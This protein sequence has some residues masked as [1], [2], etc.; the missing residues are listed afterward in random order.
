[1]QVTRRMKYDQFLSALAACAD[2]RGMDVAA[3]HDR[4]ASC[5]G[6]IVHGTQVC[7]SDPKR[8]T[9]TCTARFVPPARS[10]TSRIFESESKFHSSLCTAANVLSLQSISIEMSLVRM[11][12]DAVRF[13]DHRVLPVERKQQAEPKKNPGGRPSWTDK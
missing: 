1:M 8:T 11:Q 5:D 7:M 6:P 4:I 10:P 9:V 12:A 13:H 3:L 2:A